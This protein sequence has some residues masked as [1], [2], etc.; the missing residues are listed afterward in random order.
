[1]YLIHQPEGSEEP[2]RYK[3]NPRKLMSAEREML[4]RKTG[5][6]FT[7]FTTSVL[8]GNSLCRRA[9]LYMFQK[10]DHPTVKWDDVDFAWDEL[11]LEY[12]R[13]ELLTMREQIAENTSGDERAARLASIDEE[14]EKAIDED[15][16]GKAELPIAG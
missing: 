8:S 15:D 6:D 2:T 1:M 13:Q 7:D 5:K 14:I 16:E 3:Y 4:E 10:R 9:L 11:R 12:S